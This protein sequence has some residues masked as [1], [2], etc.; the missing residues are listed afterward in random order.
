MLLL[1]TSHLTTLANTNNSSTLS[2]N[3]PDLL[4]YVDTLSENLTD[5]G[6]V[7]YTIEKS[8]EKVNKELEKFKKNYKVT[9]N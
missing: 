2:N 6:T 8:E 4:E 9:Y 1:G 3:L 7:C 5:A